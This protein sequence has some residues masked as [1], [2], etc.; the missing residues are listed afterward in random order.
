MCS[1][2]G[3]L[4]WFGPDFFSTGARHGD[5]RQCV[6]VRQRREE[7][8]SNVRAVFPCFNFTSTAAGGVADGSVDVDL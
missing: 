4:D 3:Q 2:R 1:L 5:G 8:A 7:I 6:G